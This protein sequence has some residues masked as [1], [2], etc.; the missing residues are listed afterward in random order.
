MPKHFF[1]TVPSHLSLVHFRDTI[2]YVVMS[3]F[4]VLQ[5]LCRP[6]TLHGMTSF[7]QL[8]ILPLGSFKSCVQLLQHQLVRQPDLWPLTSHHCFFF[9]IPRLVFQSFNV[10]ATHQCS[11]A[12][13][14]LSHNPTRDRSDRNPVLP[15]QSSSNLWQGQTASLCKSSFSS[16]RGHV[17][18]VLTNQYCRQCNDVMPSSNHSEKIIYYMCCSVIPYPAENGTKPRQRK[19]CSS[20]DAW[21]QVKH[22]VC[23]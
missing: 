23:C 11:L 18:W 19:V 8:L 1:L 21:P 4:V 9:C 17:T 10:E 3:S 16:I 2:E 15:R 12:C 5:I 6:F 14:H 7:I 13:L 22:H 20:T